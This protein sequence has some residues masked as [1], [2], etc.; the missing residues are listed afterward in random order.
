MDTIWKDY[1]LN[2]EN[3]I[4][5]NIGEVN[6]HCKLNAEELLLSHY[7]KN[8]ENNQE[9]NWQRWTLK[10]KE[11]V[12]RILPALPDRPVV[13]K[14][15]N[16]FTLLKNS[17]AK[18]YVRVPLWIRIELGQKSFQNLFEIP[19]VI[20][21]NT[22]FGNFFE[23]ELSYWISSG[24]KRDFSIDKDKSY[25][26]ICPIKLVNKANED[27]SVEKIGLRVV[28]LNLYK[29]GNQIWSDQTK[30]IFTGSLEQSEIEVA[31]KAPQEA[32]NSKL[33]MKARQE[34]KNSFSAKT[35][36][37]LKELPGLGILMK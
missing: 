34:H 29:D 37:S 8:E 11:N 10:N 24:A 32:P 9:N 21:S 12:I 23:G 35:F 19:T 16:K 1:Q 14:P 33:I 7:Y 4:N 3:E 17:E 18:I 27:L 22:W 28:N 13:V 20:L 15:E 31:G 26:A 36:S 5:L 2:F 25:L 30:V 6:I